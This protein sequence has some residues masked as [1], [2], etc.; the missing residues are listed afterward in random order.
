[1]TRSPPVPSQAPA[2]HRL[3]FS[4]EAVRP[5]SRVAYWKEA[6]CKAFVR[7]D[8]DCDPHR[9]FYATLAARAMSRFDCI[10][11]SGS[12]QRVSRSAQLVDEDRT[13]G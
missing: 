1:M 4:T 13:T 5:G 10:S 2:P 9:P 8:L 7:L 3:R 6:I 11:V 12:A